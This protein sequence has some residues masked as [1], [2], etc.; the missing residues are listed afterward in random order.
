MRDDH[1][2]PAVAANER[3]QPRFGV[4]IEVIVRLVQQQ[5]VGLLDRQPHQRDQLLLPAAERVG[6]QVVIRRREAECSQQ[7]AD[8]VGVQR[9][10][11]PL[12]AF[13]HALLLGHACRAS[14]VS[15]L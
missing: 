3:L 15:S 6:R 10:A 7:L 2:R 13:Q 14:A 11:Q 9:A 4:E 12:V 5:H 8:A 1:H